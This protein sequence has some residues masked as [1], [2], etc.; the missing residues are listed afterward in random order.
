VLEVYSSDVLSVNRFRSSLLKGDG[1]PDFVPYDG[2]RR[3]GTAAIE[4]RQ[5]WIGSGGSSGGW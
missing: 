3:R 5:W 1:T 2:F 4:R